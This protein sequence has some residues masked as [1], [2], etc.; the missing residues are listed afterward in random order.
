MKRKPVNKKEKTK[1]KIGLII[2]YFHNFQNKLCG[3]N[4]EWTFAFYEIFLMKHHY[5][6]R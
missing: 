3:V 4:Q 2:T 6:P 1:E 5:V